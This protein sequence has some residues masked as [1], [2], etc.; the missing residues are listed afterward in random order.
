MGKPQYLPKELSTMTVKKSTRATR[1][2]EQ[3]A[4]EFG[5]V[6]QEVSDRSPLPDNEVALKRAKEAGLRDA[7]GKFSLEAAVTSLSTAGVGMSR[8]LTELT[9]ELQTTAKKVDELKEV[10]ALL[11]QDIEELHGKEIAA[12]ALEDMVAE[13]AAKKDELNTEFANVSRSISQQRQVLTNEWALEQQAHQQ[14]AT[15]RDQ[16]L[17]AARRREEEQYQ[18]SKLDARTRLE[19]EWSN[20]LADQKRAND[21]RQ[22]E[23]E[24]NW[25]ERT[26]ALTA[27]EAEFNALKARVDSIQNEIDAAVKREVAIATNA[28]TRDARH[29]QELANNAFQAKETVLN[30]KVENLNTQLASATKTISDLSAQ[31]ALANEKVAKIAGD[32]LSAASGRQALTEVQTMLASQQNGSQ[33]KA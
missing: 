3:T 28:V 29:A 17:L 22:A 32:A 20:K 31:L 14:A 18:F 27:K 11:E 4:K 12:S 7:A 15:R 24:R 19:V 1:T 33:K 25:A 30:A 21:I 9:V 8:A 2:K 13:F 16:E 5:V 26:A 10:K 23:L 6:E